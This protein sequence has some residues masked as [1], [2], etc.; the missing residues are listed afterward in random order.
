MVAV[1]VL[2]GQSADD[3]PT[4][5]LVVGIPHETVGVLF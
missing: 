2:H 5:V 3:I 4:V 1:V